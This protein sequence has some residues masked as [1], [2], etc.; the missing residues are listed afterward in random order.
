MEAYS[1]KI[2]YTWWIFQHAMF[3]QRMVMQL[4]DPAVQVTM[5]CCKNMLPFPDYHR[6]WHRFAKASKVYTAPKS[7]ET[8]EMF[9]LSHN[10]VRFR[11]LQNWHANIYSRYPLKSF[12]FK[13]QSITCPYFQQPHN[14]IQESPTF[15]P[16]IDTLSRIGL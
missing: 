5:K 7:P 14:A 6:T 10:T 4:K 9:I 12:S 11:S 16:S 3:D 1:W 13:V 15:S 8:A 2:I